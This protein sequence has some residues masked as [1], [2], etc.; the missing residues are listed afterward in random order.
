MGKRP[1][2]LSFHLL[3]MAVAARLTEANVQACDLSTHLAN[4]CTVG[5]TATICGV[6]IFIHYSESQSMTFG[7]Q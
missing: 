5:L 3:K 4:H 7:L 2:S 1:R 6:C